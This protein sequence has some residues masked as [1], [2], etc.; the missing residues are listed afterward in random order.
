MLGL[1]MGQSALANG[2]KRCRQCKKYFSADSGRVSNFGFFHN[3]ECL[4][5]FFEKN[6]EKVIEKARKKLAQ[7]R[8]KENAER[9]RKE[10]EG[11][12]ASREAKAKM[13][14]Q[15]KTI[16]EL[17]DEAAKLL[18]KIVRLEAADING[19]CQCVTCD[20]HDHWT[21][22]QGGHFI[23]RGNAA[24]K[25]DP[26]NINSQCSGCNLHGM[27]VGNA[28]SVYHGWM[29]NRYGK[30]VVDEMLATKGKVYKWDR[31]WVEQ[32]IIDWKKRARDLERFT[33]GL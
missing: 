14:L 15:V 10:A 11:R 32:K 24:T 5:K 4:R 18:Q 22:M 27:K 2:N 28:E 33:P 30:E 6:Q 16:G 7:D 29:I 19:F 12:K 9:K 17:T 20:K 1:E 26:R 31:E 25:L 8:R 3:D 21:N 13:K 23:S